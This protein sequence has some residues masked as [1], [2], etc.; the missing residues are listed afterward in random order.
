MI[1][2]DFTTST[3]SLTYKLYGVLSVYSGLYLGPIYNPGSG[4]AFIHLLE[5]A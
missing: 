1:Y 4:T 2:R 5:I 3:A